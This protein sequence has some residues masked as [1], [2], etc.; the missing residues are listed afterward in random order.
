MAEFN[1]PLDDPHYIDGA[2]SLIIDG[3]ELLGT[4]LWDLVDQ[5]WCYIANGLVEAAGGRTFSTYFP[6]QPLQISF[7]PLGDNVKIIIDCDPFPK[8]VLVNLQTILNAVL[9][10]MD[11]L[12]DEFGKL[13]G[14][15]TF[16]PER[17][18][19]RSALACLRNG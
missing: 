15:T 18:E 7:T 5:L 1:G 14:A 19:L 6:D 4:E 12:A 13:D 8:S 3:V 10:H 17:Q 11:D 9:R 16:A 2:I